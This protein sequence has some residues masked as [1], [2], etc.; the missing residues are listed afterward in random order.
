MRYPRALRLL[1]PAQ[2]QRVFR[3]CEAR[4]SD[5]YLTVLACSNALAHPR[6]GTTVSIRNA[7]N[8]VKRNRIKRLIKESFRLNQQQLAGWDLVV[9]ARAGV[10]S[11]TNRQLFNTL[12]THWRK[13][14]AHANTGTDTD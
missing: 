8:A 3:L 7:G 2:Y 12:E 4:S 6:L 1:A 10:S 14:A 13:I 5:K 11:R 9:V